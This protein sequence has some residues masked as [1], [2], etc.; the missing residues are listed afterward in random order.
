MRQQIEVGEQV[1]V[2]RGEEFDWINTGATSYHI[3]ITITDNDPP[4]DS[5]RYD[6]APGIP[7]PARARHSARVGGDH[8]YQCV[9]PRIK[10]NPHII[11]S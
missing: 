11:I 5:N 10:T 3:E 9:P 1:T 6:V 7:E 4:L 2:K 8:E